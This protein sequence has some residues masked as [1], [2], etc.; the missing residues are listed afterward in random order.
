MPKEPSVNTDIKIYTLQHITTFRIVYVSKKILSD[1]H[2]QI[3]KGKVKFHTN[4]SVIA[5]I[6]PE[7]IKLLITPI[8]IPFNVSFII[9][10]MYNFVHILCVWQVYIILFHWFDFGFDEGY[11]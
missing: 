8:I 5:Y 7:A 9:S 4:D 1:I 11:F 3:H 10:I 6:I 2:N